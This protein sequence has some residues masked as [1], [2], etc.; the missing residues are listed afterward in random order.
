MSG[1]ILIVLGLAIR[2]WAKKIL[3]QDFQEVIQVPSKVVTKGPYR[4]VN[5]PMYLGSIIVILGASL[6]HPAF[7]ITWLAYTFY[8]SRS[9]VEDMIIKEKKNA[10]SAHT[11]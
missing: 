7:G 4:Y 3:A 9:V 11:I 2:F 1:I 10:V 8:R 5:H 6:L